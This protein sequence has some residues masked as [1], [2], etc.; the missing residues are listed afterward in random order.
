MPMLSTLSA[1]AVTPTPIKPT[2]DSYSD[3]FLIVDVFFY[4]TGRRQHLKNIWQ[5]LSLK[6]IKIINN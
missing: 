5:V 1:T 6:L 2:S 3:N 4:Q